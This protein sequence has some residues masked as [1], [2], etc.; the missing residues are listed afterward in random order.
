MDDIGRCVEATATATSR[1]RGLTL[2]AASKLE[3]DVR[4]DPPPGLDTP[5]KRRDWASVKLLQLRNPSVAETQSIGDWFVLFLLD[6]DGCSEKVVAIPTQ[7]GET[8]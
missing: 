7:R 8:L 6:D 2:D 1:Y 4:L 3:P 5:D